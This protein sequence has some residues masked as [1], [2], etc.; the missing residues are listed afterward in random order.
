MAGPQGERLH[1]YW[2]D[3]LRGDIE[4]LRLPYDRPR[5]ATPDYRGASRDGRIDAPLVGAARALATAEQTSLYTVLLAAFL[6]VLHRYTSARRILVGTPAAGRPATRFDEV[7]GY[8]MN[9]VVITDDVDPEQGFRAMLRRV[10]GTV[11]EAVDNSHYPFIELVDAL[12]RDGRAVPPSL[13]T[14]AF[15]FQNWVRAGEPAARGGSAA[16]LRGEGAG[17]FRGE[18][19][20]VHQEGEFDLT[21]EVVEDADEC[22]FTVKY[23]P[24]LFDAATVDRLGGHLVRLLRSAVTEPDRAVGRL[25]MLTAEEER[26]L[27]GAVEAARRDYPRDRLAYELFESAAARTP[28]AVAVLHQDRSL[29]YAELAAQVDVLTGDLRARGVAPGLTVGVLLERSPELLVALLAVMKAGGAYVPLDPHYPAERLAYMA[30]DAQ[31]CLVVTDSTVEDALDGIPVPRLRLDTDADADADASGVPRGVSAAGEAVRAGPEDVAYV[32]YTSG[33]TGQPKGVEVTHRGLTNLLT[34]MACEPGLGPDDHLLAL[35]TVCFDIAALELFG[36]LAVGAR[37]E[38]VAADVARDGVRLRRVLDAGDATVVQATPTTWRMLCAAGWSGRPGLRVLCGGEALDRRTADDL[39]AGG[40]AV[41]NLYGPTETTIWSAVQRLHPGERITIGR[42]IANTQLH[43]LDELRQPTPTGVAG[44]LYIGGD[45]LARGYLG[46]P[47]LTR[48]RFVANP[49]GDAGSARLYRTGDLARALPDGRVEILGRVDAQVKIRGCR[50]EPE[51]VEVALRRLP[52]VRAAAAVARETAP[53]SLALYGFCVLDADSRLPERDSLRAWLPEHLMPD[54]LVQLDALPQTANGKIDRS[55]LASTRFDAPRRF[56]AQRHADR[57][58]HA[59]HTDAIRGST[60]GAEALLARMIGEIVHLE[61]SAV[62]STIPFGELGLDSVGCT[63]L[64]ARISDRFGVELLP[65]TFYRFP[66]LVALTAHLDIAYP[67]AFRAERPA[68][69][70]TEPSEPRA[71]PPAPPVGRVAAPTVVPQ[72]ERVA[73]PAE[74]VASSAEAVAIIG[75]AGRLP[76]S[77]DLDTFWR[78]LEAGRDLVEEIPADRWDWRSQTT[79]PRTGDGDGRRWGGFVADVDRFDAAFFGISP[80][81]AELMDPQQRLLLEVVWSAVEDAGYPPT[82]LAGRRVG[83]FVGVTNSD[84]LDVQRAA[85]RGPEGHTLTGAALSIIANRVSYLLD[86]RGPSV[87]VDTACSGSLTAVH[88]AVTALRDGSCD[89]AIAGGVSLILS[90]TLYVALGKSEMLSEDGRCKTFDRRANG[91]VRGEGVGVVVL[92]RLADARRDGDPLRAVVRGT[93]LNHG[94]RTASLTSPN[95]DVQADLIVDAYRASGVDPVTVGYVEA[96]GTGTA[97]GDPIEVTGLTTAFARLYA[98][99]GRTVPP[100]PTCAIGSV[101]TNIGHLEAAAGIAGLLKVVLALQH[102]TIPASLHFQ[103]RNPYVDLT[104][105]PFFIAA[106][107]RAWDPPTDERNAPLPRLAGVSSF[108]FGGAN[109]HVVVEEAPAPAAGAGRRPAGE[110]V[111]VLSARDEAA[112]TR[113]ARHLSA[114]L[115]RLATEGPRPC[116]A[117]VAYTLQVGR[118]AMTERLAIVAV[119]LARLIER[120]DGFVEGQGGTHQGVFRGTAAPG[121]GRGD[122][123]DP[124]D[125]RPDVLARRW[126][127]G[128]TVDWHGWYEGRAPR[129]IPLPTYPFARTRHWVA[130]DPAPPPAAVPADAGGPA[131]A[132]APMEFTTPLTGTESFLRDHVIDG[133]MLLPG[134]VCLDLART[135]GE[136]HRG[137]G[138]AVRRISDIGWLSPVTVAPHRESR[139]LVRL[140]AHREVDLLGFTVVAASG[141]AGERVCARGTLEFG[142]VRTPVRRPAP[143]DLAAIRARCGQLLSGQQCYRQMERMGCRYGPSLQVIGEL[144][145]GATEALAELRLPSA[146]RDGGTDDR[147]HASLLDGALQTV[148]W[149]ISGR[150][151]T[152]RVP[153]LPYSVK[154]VELFGHLPPV[155]FAHATRADGPCA[156]GASADGASADG[157]TAEEASAG[158]QLFDIVLTDPAGAVVATIDGLLLRVVPPDRAAADQRVYAFAPVWSPAGEAVVPLPGMPLPLPGRPFTLPGR[159]STLS[160]GR[161][162]VPGD[163]RVAVPPGA[164]VVVSADIAAGRRLADALAPHIRAVHVVAGEAVRQPVSPAPLHIVHL[165]SA[166]RTGLWQAVDAGFHTA[167]GL[168]RAWITARRAE[169]RYL[170]VYAADSSAEAAH[171][172]MSGV[173]YCL[174]TEYPALRMRTVA[175]RNA[176]DLARLILHELATPD[177]EVEVRVEGTQRF[178]RAWQER[179]LPPATTGSGPLGAD[180]AHLVTGGGGRLG[181]FVAERLARRPGAE[182]V[183]AGRSEPTPPARETI[184]RLRAG[185]ATVVYVRADVAREDDVAGLVREARERFGRIVGVTHAAGVLRDG[186]LL[187][188]SH[189]DAE[190]VLAPKAYGAVWLDEATKDEPLEYFV[191][192]SSVAAV[193]GAAGQSDYA[194]ANAFADQVV[195]RRAD[196]RD[197]GAR[198]GR[199][200]S[201]NWPLW[202]DGG[203]GADPAVREW[204]WQ[205]LGIRP[206]PTAV[207]VDAFEAALATTG[208]RLLLATG[209]EGRIHRALAGRNGGSVR[210]TAETRPSV[211]APVGPIPVVPVGAVPIDLRPATEDL[212]RRLL[213]RELRMPL[214]EVSESGPFERYGID[215]L[216][217][218]SL[219]RELEKLFGPLSKTLFFEYRNVGEL[220]GYLLDHNAGALRAHFDDGDQDGIA[221]THSAAQPADTEPADA[222][223]ATMPAVRAKISAGPAARGGTAA[224]DPD[225]GTDI[226]IIGVSGRYPQAD[227]LWQFWRNLR[228]GR[229]CVEEIPADRWDHAR[230]FEPDRAAPG[231]AYAKWGGFLRD[232]DRFDPLFFRMSQLEAEHIDPQERIFLE[233]VWHLL[234]D[235]GHTRQTLAPAR[236][237][238]F[239]GV[240]YGHYQLY[241]VEEALRGDG[242]P[243]SSSYASVANRVSYFFDFT[244]PSLAIDTMCSSS[245]VAIHLACQSIR[246]GDCDVAVAGGVN[247]SSH[248]V[249]YLQLCQRNFLSTDGRCRSFG[250]DGDGYVPGEGSG[251]V[252]LKRL[253]AARADGDRILAIVKG[254]AV[255]HGGTGKGYGVPNPTAQGDLIGD[256]LTRAGLDPAMLGYL[257]A[258][259]TGTALGDPIEIS[260]LVRA[261]R[262]QGNRCPIGSVKSNIGHAESAAGIAGVTKVLLQMRHATV[263]AVTARRAAQPQCGLRPDTVRRPARAGTVARAGRRRRGH[264]AAGSRGQRVRRGRHERTRT[265]SGGPDPPAA[266]GGARRRAAVPVRALRPHRGQPGRA[267]EPD[268]VVPARRWRRPGAGGDGVHAPGRARGDGPPARDRLRRPGGVAGPARPLRRRRPRHG[269]CLD[270]RRRPTPRTRGGGVAVAGGVRPGLGGRWHR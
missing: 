124:A 78:H 77:P 83:V 166:G 159:A 263:G 181:L 106:A 128:G 251:A 90:P 182:I 262:G 40:A 243:P 254:S 5:P 130:P 217:V 38:I 29:T 52:G 79:D 230:F 145:Y 67:G 249:K 270:R 183:L 14:V 54:A 58:A 155:C 225:A 20:A 161:G 126:V 74:R 132:E 193:L 201:I 97:L 109:A 116:P 219:T 27:S 95:P 229:D 210:L 1:D 50:V 110:L 123:S 72:A 207:G 151:A 202:T 255:N 76:G 115:R 146:R 231:R 185:G 134:V 241:G 257:E 93:A 65:T 148:G 16:P 60:G 108:G 204:M 198:S 178:V 3:R 256:A 32:I 2:L 88:Q 131:S 218:M 152:A 70:A 86:L 94:G 165:A 184:A 149:L 101:K 63:T 44:E 188:K 112:L 175:H 174:R 48:E 9:L 99:A 28:D 253:S 31:L 138:A 158:G 240:M 56:D 252:L 33:S 53:G 234:E 215:S 239:V 266:C 144:R 43:V 195:A 190:A 177:D 141:S 26:L 179:E 136:R 102:A 180:G 133:A 10:R 84:Y 117:E 89:V 187:H 59:P 265:P 71:A 199:S 169:A 160:S 211:P 85:G 171:A 242:F 36:P 224:G 121:D 157:A 66:T 55:A 209:D 258:H 237:G 105:S 244:G 100:Q 127:G 6:V 153:Y 4:P 17:L 140:A 267:R 162:P 139:L 47:E 22:R 194:Y 200:L 96:H 227:D 173:A 259:G 118:D 216:L 205:E 122:A 24:G 61:P 73:V 19:G 119:D 156:D 120:L 49:I 248:P 223:T 39:L 206:L 64:S 167:L 213:A 68:G 261:F 41:W 197:R 25:D 137:G 135:A 238:V 51:E 226:A 250:A 103:E 125:A 113:Y 82:A 170:Y 46:R 104:G 15:Y 114:F 214:E 246:D 228:D 23:H 87:A 154:A 13:V 235:A 269:G 247:V 57:S 268:G 191:T 111:F 203:M 164:V 7:V 176:P 8:F 21:L 107:T 260:G 208:S 186:F 45:G 42:P 92:R 212:L 222:G 80:R 81:E 75:M 30:T 168:C 129:R 236:T 91:Y 35:T 196:L 143:V 232:V 220:A 62:V 34:S 147:F 150:D 163:G 142:A 264:A 12:R 69:T 189:E 172:A 11:L 233:T 221:A 245:L 18:F 37:V 98:A 192:F